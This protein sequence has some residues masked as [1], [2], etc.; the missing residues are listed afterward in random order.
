MDILHLSHHITVE[1]A[2]SNFGCVFPLATLRDHGVEDG[3][4]MILRDDGNGFLH[5]ASFQQQAKYALLAIVCTSGALAQFAILPA[6]DGLSRMAATGVL[7]AV[8]SLRIR[9]WAYEIWIRGW[10]PPSK[11]KLLEL[12]SKTREKPSLHWIS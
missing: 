10:I 12:Q 2:R 4:N 6:L 1:R 3:A 11:R 8:T 9:S 7:L 5:S